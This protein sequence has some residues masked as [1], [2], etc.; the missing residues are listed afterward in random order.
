MPTV[1]TSA[2][3]VFGRPARV[4]VGNPTTALGAGLVDLSSVPRAAIQLQFFRQ[5][6]SNE[7]NQMLKDGAFGGLK[8]ARITLRL[9]SAQAAWLA[10]LMPEVTATTDALDFRNSNAVLT[11]PSLIIV[12]EEAYGSAD[13]S[14]FVWYV[15][16]VAMVEDPGEFVFKLEETQQSGEPFDVTLQALLTA[17]DQGDVALADGKQIIFRGSKPAGWSFPTGY[18]S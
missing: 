1:T 13:A 4:L 17:A 3:N 8:G 9:F 11:P 12:P 5:I 6:V 7:M 10:A 18:G 16:S 15:P 2:A 14:D